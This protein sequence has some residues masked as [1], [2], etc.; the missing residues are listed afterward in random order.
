MTTPVT[1]L[2]QPAGTP[3]NALDVTDLQQML[4]N[5]TA[6]ANAARDRVA[7]LDQEV[8]YLRDRLAEAQDEIE[9]LK[10][11]LF[12][13]E[14]SLPLQAEDDTRELAT[15][16]RFLRSGQIP[17]GIAELERVLDRAHPNWRQFA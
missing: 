4:A 6:L 11:A 5:Q 10:D 2:H 8:G 7:T 15:A 1:P 13:A 3:G 9:D 12:A 14:E 17:E 16:R